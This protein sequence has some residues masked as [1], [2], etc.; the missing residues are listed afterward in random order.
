MDPKSRSHG[1]SGLFAQRGGYSWGPGWSGRLL[2]AM[3]LSTA[4]FALGGGIAVVTPVAVGVYSAFYG[5]DDKDDE[6]DE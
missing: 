1:L 5:E 3:G 4:I 6:D 2:L